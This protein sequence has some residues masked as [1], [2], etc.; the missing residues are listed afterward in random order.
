[1]RL[2]R[3]DAAIAYSTTISTCQ[4]SCGRMPQNPHG[5]SRTFPKHALLQDCQFDYTAR[6]CEK[7]QKR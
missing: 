4:E 5:T 2:G 6:L 1:M 7:R 3:S